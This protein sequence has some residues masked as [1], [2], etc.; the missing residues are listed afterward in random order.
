MFKGDVVHSKGGFVISVS[1][2]AH[3]ENVSVEHAR[4]IAKLLEHEG[5]LDIQ[6]TPTGR[7]H[8]NIVGYKVLRQA[9]LESR[10][11]AA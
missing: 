3:D 8:L 2:V 6:R 1:L 10:T 11:V 5:A 7:M 4:R 9:I